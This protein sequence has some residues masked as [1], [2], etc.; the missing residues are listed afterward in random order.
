[1][2]LLEQWLSYPAA[3]DRILSIIGIE[4]HWFIL[5]YVLG[6]PLVILVALLAYK[7][8]ANES[9]LKLARTSAKAL[10]LVFAV[11]AASGTAS[12]FGLLVIWP[13]LLE[14]AGRYIYFPLYVEIFAFLTE[15]TFIYL[16]VFGWGKLSLN[17]RIAVAFLA[18]LGAWLSGAMIMSVNSYMVAPTGVSPAF[19][20]EAGWLYSQG[21][22]KILLVVP[23][24]L[25]DA[26]D[27]GKLQSLGMEVV[28]RVGGGV[29]VYMPSRIVARL[30][31]E[32]WGG[33]T[34][35]ESV[36]ALVVKPEAL[37]SLKA[38]LVKD[39]VDAVLTE[40]VRTVGYTTVTFKSP[41]FVG[42]FLHAVGA[43][44]TV[45]GFTIAGAYALLSLL[46]RRESKYYADGLRFGVVFSLVA[47]AVQGA[48]FGHVIG[49]EIAKYNPEK[50]AAMEGTSK[51]V[52]SIPRALG[53]ESLM[54]AIIFGNPGAAMPSYD[55]IPVDYCRL[56]N[57]PPV[58][59]CRPP[60]I[61][62]Y[63][64]YSK[65]GLSLLLGLLAL[66]GTVLIYTGRA[67]GRLTLYGF[68]VSPVI[69]HAVS[70]LGWA[71]RE[72][73]RKPWTI[74][75]VMTVDVAHTANPAGA[76]EYAVVAS[77]FLGVLA[78]LIYASWRILLAPSLRGGGE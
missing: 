15:I 43:A 19:S 26:L 10:G 5:Q 35:G 51:A 78:A 66:A 58:Q 46:S 29:A 18:L 12:E 40:T 27:V 37:P 22:P 62:H 14:A 45:T 36:L 30:A 50:L 49:T 48:V 42:S 65:I 25:V 34:V 38:T 71:V 20:Q 64:Y 57:L 60:L 33:R 59:D 47:V 72:M 73:G 6:L 3:I 9:W 7:R 75:G 28:G 32:A 39:V 76:A 56:D 11:G 41:V 63:L 24:R 4:I 61:L 17:G 23:E 68:A 13:N 52:L 31:Y 70:F 55:E 2:N 54:K 67:P 74:Y 16:L 53:I 77:I 1:M 69:A 8:T 44:L 21:Y